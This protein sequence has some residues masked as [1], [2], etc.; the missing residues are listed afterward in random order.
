MEGFCRRCI[1]QNGVL[2]SNDSAR[3][4]VRG[5]QARGGF[6]ACWGLGAGFPAH[7]KALTIGPYYG[8][9]LTLNPEPV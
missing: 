9:H 5:I 2:Y 3:L 7:C 8:P 4:S 1:C 6:R